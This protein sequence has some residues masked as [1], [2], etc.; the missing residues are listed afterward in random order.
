M[1]T[2]EWSNW[3]KLFP[4]L[5]DWFNA[6][7]SKKLFPERTDCFK[8][9]EERAF[10]LTGKQFENFLS[11]ITTFKLHKLDDKEL[12]Y[13]IRIILQYRNGRGSSVILGDI[14]KRILLES[15]KRHYI[16]E[17]YWNPYNEMMLEELA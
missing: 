16:S 14:G 17:G 9:V 7:I 6:E 15:G 5:E 10:C 3:Q 2:E 8:T 11:L 12:E 1:D 13:I 4:E